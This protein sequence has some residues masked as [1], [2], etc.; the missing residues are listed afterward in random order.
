MEIILSSI[1]STFFGILAYIATKAID[2]DNRLMEEI[3]EIQ[4][5]RYEEFIDEMEDALQI[6]LKSIKNPSKKNEIEALIHAKLNK[7]T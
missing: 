2:K 5:K 1:I 3:R 6:G 4:R 7:L